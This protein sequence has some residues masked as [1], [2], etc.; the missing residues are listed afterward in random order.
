MS[1]PTEDQPRRRR[2]EGWGAPTPTPTPKPDQV[3]PLTTE[4]LEKEDTSRRRQYQGWGAPTPAAEPSAAA[5]PIT[6]RAQPTKEEDSGAEKTIGAVGDLWKK[7]RQTVPTVP[8]TPLGAIG[9]LL[10][11][12]EER[13]AGKEKEKEAPPLKAAPG[14]AILKKKI[15]KTGKE[16]E[17][18]ADVRGLSPVSQKVLT[19]WISITPFDKEGVEAPESQIQVPLLTYT[20]QPKFFQFAEDREVLNQPA[21]KSR[22]RSVIRTIELSK[23]G[24]TSDVGMS[25]EER[26]ALKTRIEGRVESEMSQAINQTGLTF[27]DTDPE[28]TARKIAEGDDGIVG[29]ILSRGMKAVLGEEWGEELFEATWVPIDAVMTPATTVKLR[30][31]QGL[32]QTQQHPFWHYL[33]ASVGVLGSWWLSDDPDLD[34]G[35]AEHVRMIRSNYSLFDDYHK[36]GEEIMDLPMMRPSQAMARATLGEKQATRNEQVAGFL[37]A[38]TLDVGLFDLG[39]AVVGKGIKAAR[40]GERMGIGQ[41]GRMADSKKATD[42]ILRGIDDGSITSFGEMNEAFLHNEAARQS[43]YNEFSSLVSKHDGSFASREMDDLL[44]K[45]PEL[46]ADA[47]KAHVAA[48]AAAAGRGAAQAKKAALDSA[49]AF[50]ETVLKQNRISLATAESTRDALLA[51][52]RATFIAHGKDPRK[53]AGMTAQRAMAGIHK[54]T[55]DLAETLRQIGI[56]SAKK[57]PSAKQ[58]AR[59]ARLNKKQADLTRKQAYWRAQVAVSSAIKHAKHEAKAVSA[60]RDMVSKVRKAAKKPVEDLKAIGDAE[61]AAHQASMEASRAQN[62]MPMAKTV[63]EKMSASYDEGIKS[64]RATPGLTRLIDD[65]YQGVL[66][67]LTAKGADKVGAT[68]DLKQ[69]E[70]ELVDKYG[71]R[72]LDKFERGEPTALHR[73]LWGGPRTRGATP[74]P[75]PAPSPGKKVARKRGIRGMSDWRPIPEAMERDLRQF[76]TAR[77][78]AEYLATNS[79]NKAYRAIAKRIARYVGGDFHI[80]EPPS[81]GVFGHGVNQF[82]DIV[83]N[84]SI[85]DG[86]ARTN[87]VGYA[88]HGEAI[89]IKGRGWDLD[90]YPGEKLHGLKEIAGLTE[91]TILHELL[92]A[93]TQNQ[94]TRAF[95]ERKSQAYKS[96]WSI[97]S[98]LRIHVIGGSFPPEGL[99]A[100][101]HITGDFVDDEWV[102]STAGRTYKKSREESVHELVAMAFTD[103]EA[104]R[105]LKTVVARPDFVVEDASLWTK[106]VDAIRDL[107]G[108]DKKHHTMLDQVIQTTDHMWKAADEAGYQPR[109]SV[110][111]TVAFEEWMDSRFIDNYTILGK[112]YE[113]SVAIVAEEV[114][115]RWEGLSPEQRVHAGRQVEAWRGT[116]DPD[117][118]P[119]IVEEFLEK[120]GEWEDTFDWDDHWRRLAD[121]QPS[122]APAVPSGKVRLTPEVLAELHAAERTLAK[123]ARGSMLTDRN[124]IYA[125]RVLDEAG[126]LAI[127]LGKFNVMNTR[128]W[129]PT[130]QRGIR[131]VTRHITDSRLG[132]GVSS[133]LGPM[134]KEMEG[135]YTR[136]VNWLLRAQ[137]EQKALVDLAVKRQRMVYDPDLGKEVPHIPWDEVIE[138][139]LDGGLELTL[140]T[141]QSVVNRGPLTI[142]Q[143]AFK[144]IRDLPYTQALLRGEDVGDKEVPAFYE[145]LARMWLPDQ[146]IRDEQRLAAGTVPY[147]HQQVAQI[148]E[149]GGD[150]LKWGGENGFA[151]QLRRRTGTLPGVVAKK[152]DNKSLLFGLQALTSAALRHQLADDVA[153]TV[154]SVSDDTARRLKLMMK[155]GGQGLARDASELEDLY[156]TLVAY[157]MPSYA[158]RAVKQN[159]GEM[160]EIAGT[161]DGVI[162]RQSQSGELVF[163]PNPLLKALDDK[164]QD[165]VKHLAQYSAKAEPTILKGA[166]NKF[167]DWSSIWRQD[168][169]TGIGLPRGA[170]FV[171]TAASDFAQMGLSLG[172]GTAARLS[173]QNGFTNL[174][175]VGG[176]YQDFL[177]DMSRRL[178]EKGS[179]MA[180][181]INALMNP[182]LAAVWR[183]EDRLIQTASGEI[184]NLKDVLKMATE[185]GVME[186]FYRFDQQ[187]VVAKVTGRL[188]KQGVFG[189]PGTGKAG[190]VWSQA[191]E[192]PSTMMSVVQQ[193]QRM[194]VYL[195]YLINRGAGRKGAKKAVDEALYDW[196][197]GVSEW[198]LH[199]ISKF[200]AF[201]RY[202]RLSMN[203]V[204]NIYADLLR[205]PSAEAMGKAQRLRQMSQASIYGPQTLDELIA[206]SPDR[207]ELLNDQ[208]QMEAFM[209]AQTPAYL[210]NIR[211]TSP[212]RELDEKR[213]RQLARSVPGTDRYDPTHY[214]TRYPSLGPPEAFEMWLNIANGIYGSMKILGKPFGVSEG[215]PESF[216]TETARPLTE[217]FLPG[218]QTG[219]EATLDATVGTD[220]SY[221]SKSL[222]RGEEILFDSVKD[223]VPSAFFNWMGRDEFTGKTTMDPAILGALRQIP[224]LST[225][226]VR[227]AE[228]WGGAP[229]DA[230]WAEEFDQVFQVFTGIKDVPFSPL[231]EHD[232][233]VRA[234]ESTLKQRAD[235]L[236]EEADLRLERVRRKD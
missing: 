161:I 216:Y 197:H 231:A 1:D 60:A 27:G 17:V 163:I 151:E 66:P 99:R 121:Y 63:L 28:D 71:Q 190:E 6:P 144:A 73:L 74:S 31:R 100:L 129:K 102:W 180:T 51:Q 112:D 16:E 68:L 219:V 78:A 134:S 113:E 5:P 225:A 22:L 202:L 206:A 119:K 67:K 90:H 94:I 123:Q 13:E 25:D 98:E 131:Q 175:L 162:R 64:L 164:Q 108:V 70:A 11:S 80:V 142:P 7:A 35:S 192:I 183:N 118:R 47:Q 214:V 120:F 12:K 48:R 15:S 203:Q 125:Q 111:E 181:P 20:H 97:I 223:W 33:N 110:D 38:M 4:P 209:R 87:A 226:A 23:M 185:D 186:T 136:A 61:V 115:W 177:S 79:E 158:H 200:A 101:A 75:M 160:R 141:G 152:Q 85:V 170:H 217:I 167:V 172:W 178:G 132:A 127:T 2:Y 195:E 72:A 106:F 46:A 56:L 188:D 42:N 52:H 211:I 50:H 103:P 77:E 228:A 10:P 221:R 140:P 207:E 124:L 54:N 59:L 193:R 159:F 176:R 18:K 76:S 128:T 49:V 174:P 86:F 34:F 153:Q 182:H 168:R 58:Q 230:T 135:T 210:K 147:V 45:I 229:D 130:I 96:F 36:L 187:Q 236:K 194:G 81:P 3:K 84:S 114:L 69:V 165:I 196:T 55:K 37:G 30:D 104:Q 227:Q 107:F 143:M 32:K 157:G 145:A 41:L 133:R 224:V 43:F 169:V 218:I 235:D 8:M 205:A 166:W 137:D 82:G 24:R 212:V 184:I 173:F 14:E 44:E 109:K 62:L 117:K 9:K 21:F 201:Y 92:H 93:A 126:E 215:V 220:L 122:P 95:R 204:A 222:R 116:F 53:A 89:Y 83:E 19:D 91:Q 150:T 189:I 149:K 154:G 29:K 179:V 155:G 233:A 234:R 191:R 171:M 57:T 105:W 198:E 40:L 138:E 208:E 146:T 156:E 65:A 148:I 232:R 199:S 139:Y 88:A 26:E 213:K 39:T